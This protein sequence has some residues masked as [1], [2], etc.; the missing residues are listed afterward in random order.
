YVCGISRGSSELLDCYPNYVHL[1][2]DLQQTN[3]LESIIA[4]A[5]EQVDHRSMDMVCL[6]NNA[7]MLEPLLPI[8]KCSAKEIASHI[9]V[10]LMAPMI[11][12]S[13]FIKLTEHWNVRR[14]VIHISSGSGSYPNPSMSVYSTAKAGL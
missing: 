4:R 9:Q 11:L 3:E 5:L 2:F 6:I 1:Q 8:E 13:V 14:K 12:T 10:T 7:A